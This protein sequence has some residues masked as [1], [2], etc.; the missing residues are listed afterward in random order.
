M[1]LG[2]RKGYSWAWNGR[3][4]GGALAAAGY[5]NIKITGTTTVAPAS[6][7]SVVRR[8]R[9]A[10]GYTTQRVTKSR[11][12][13]NTSSAYRTSSCYT[14]YYY[15]YDEVELDCWGGSY[16][17]ANYGFTIPSNAYNITRGVSGYQGCCNTSGVIS[18]TGARPTSTYYRVSVKVTGWRKYTVKRV[19]VTYSY[20]RRI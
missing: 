4:N 11:T 8:V 17:K 18:K 13:Y 9:L 12:G 14:S 7:K 16:A 10:T 2:T 3:K 15:Y 1:D 5:Y 6:T 19:S 20:K